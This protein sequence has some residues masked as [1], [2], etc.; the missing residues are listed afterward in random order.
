MVTSLGIVTM[1]VL[2]APLYV[3]TAQK[4]KKFR[5]LKNRLTLTNFVLIP[6]C[7]SQEMRDIDEEKGSIAELCIYTSEEYSKYVLVTILECW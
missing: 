7:N 2:I 4:S 1:H 3:V 6:V 5:I